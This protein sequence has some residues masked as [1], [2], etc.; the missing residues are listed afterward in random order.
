MH[1]RV[2]KPFSLYWNYAIQQFKVGEEHLGELA[3]HL[4]DNAPVGAV[5]VLDDDRAEVR[6]ATSTSGP[7]GD[8][9]DD[10]QDLGTGDGDQSPAGGDGMPPIDGTIGDLMAWVGDDKARAA[11]ALTAEQAKDK[12]RTT[13]VKQLTAIAGVDD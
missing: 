3:R 5:D 12:P 4:A 9:Q 7:A 6:A 13:F 2:L 10:G 1:V 11:Q 8:G